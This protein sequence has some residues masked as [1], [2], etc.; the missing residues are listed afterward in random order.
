MKSLRDIV[1]SRSMGAAIHSIMFRYFLRKKLPKGHCGKNSFIRTPSW[2]NKGGLEN[3][4][5]GD[6]CRVGNDNIIYATGG[7]FIMEGNT[8]VS[9]GL[10]VITGN[11]TREKGLWFLQTEANN[12]EKDVIIEKDC[13]LGMNVILLPGAHIGRGATIGAGSVVTKEI[14]PYAIAVGN[15]A[16]VIKFNFTPEEIIE[17]EQALYPENERLPL[18][19]L[20]KNYDMY[21]VDNQL[22]NQSEGGAKD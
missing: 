14:P 5:L 6:N 7:R 1:M 16:R 21:Y 9:C 12:V 19:L 4:Y 13:W 17:H 2:I 10:R 20:K 3:I 8:D 18:E 22:S 11:H 15:P